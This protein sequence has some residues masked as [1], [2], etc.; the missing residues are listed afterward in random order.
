MAYV[1][2]IRHGQASA[3][4]KDYDQLSE[5]GYKQ[6]SILKKY[7][8]DEGIK[9]TQVFYG[10]RK[11]HKQT[12][13]AI[14]SQTWPRAELLSALDEYPAHE[15]LAYGMEQ[16]LSLEPKLQPYA[17]V[18]R[19][20]DKSAGTEF[21]VLL[22]H[23]TKHW[24][25]GKLRDPNIE[26]YSDYRLR[27]QKVRE[28]ITNAADDDC[29]VL[30]SSAGFISSFLSYIV[31]GSPEQSLNTAWALYNACINVLVSKNVIS[32]AAVNQIHFLPKEMRTFI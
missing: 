2:L 12:V 26:T 18:I 19:S 29:V 14:R 27:L 31:D 4:A 25:T 16:L 32:T 17:N 3:H 9:P 23:S 30:V 21:V 5:L 8:Q 20:S 15:M 1:I 28:V 22:Q 6:C 7:L 11:R 10:P 13:D 24:M